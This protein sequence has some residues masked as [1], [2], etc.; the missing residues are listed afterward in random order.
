MNLWEDAKKIHGH[1]CGGLAW[2]VIFVIF[3]LISGCGGEE[4]SYVPAGPSTEIKKGLSG[5]NYFN[6]KFGISIPNLPMDT[7]TVK[8]LGKDGQGFLMQQEE[9]FIPMYLLLLMEPVPA[10][11]YV[12]PDEKGYINPVLD[13]NIPCIV[14]FVNYAKGGSFENYQIPGMLSSYIEFWSL[15]VESKKPVYVGDAAGTQAVLLESD[16]NYKEVITWFA[17]GELLV[18]Y[19]YW[20]PLSEFDKY[21]DVYY[22]V[23]ENINLMGK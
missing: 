1:E 11:Q 7:W 14:L 5:G 9:G 12:G 15:V 13:A 3:F 20:A 16:G 8:A 2:A 17:K 23:L 18:R 22:Q 19:E 6:T 4:D 10:H 21:Q